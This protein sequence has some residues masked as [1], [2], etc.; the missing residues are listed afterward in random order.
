[1]LSHTH[2]VSVA[3]PRYFS[4]FGRSV[5]L[6]GERY[7]SHP[8]SIGVKKP[9]KH[10]ARPVEIRFPSMVMRFE[11]EGARITLSELER[12]TRSIRN[13]PACE[14]GRLPEKSIKSPL[15]PMNEAVNRLSDDFR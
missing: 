12:S 2:G 6:T 14:A 8:I 15:R 7:I 10:Q 1:M 11:G 13:F 5:N 4:E 3:H 9:V